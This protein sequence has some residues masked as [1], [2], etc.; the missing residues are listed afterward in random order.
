MDLNLNFASL[1][2]EIHKDIQS[3]WYVP[4]V[5]EQWEV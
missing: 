1:K 4:F 2:E 5:S 3:N